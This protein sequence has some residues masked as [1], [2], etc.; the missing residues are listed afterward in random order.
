MVRFRVAT[1]NIHKC[2]GFDRKTSPERIIA[3][4]SELKAD[5]LCLQ[6][7]VDAPDGPR[8]FDQAREIS[9]A[10]PDYERYFGS[11]RS[12]RG[13]S[14]GN[15][16]LTRFRLKN[17]QNHDLSHRMRER[18]GVLQTDIHIKPDHFIR[19]FNLHLG[20]G[21][22]ERRSQAAKLLST[23]VLGRHEL[24]SPRLVVGDFNEWAPGL[25]TRSLRAT[26]K[27]FQP[28]HGLGFPRTYPGMLPL[29]SLDHC[30]YERPLELESTRLWRT[31]QA[32]IASDHL[33]LIADFC[34]R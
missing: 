3:V 7:V 11:N 4:L 29:L 21:Y 19:V 27:T 17:W 15:M 30:Y 28:R 32:L 12:H 24:E 26:F 16:T 34:I 25:I 5:I 31:R 33:P 20:T 22:M 13:G 2:R 8:A 6:E 9:R 14:Y 23:N 10:F 18:R 1:Y